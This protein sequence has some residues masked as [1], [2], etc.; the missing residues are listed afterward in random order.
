MARSRARVYSPFRPQ[1]TPEAEGDEDGSVHRSTDNVSL[2][3]SIAESQ[4]GPGGYSTRPTK[5]PSPSL[6]SGSSLANTKSDGRLL[7]A[8][9][10]FSGSRQPSRSMVTTLSHRSATSQDGYSVRAFTRLG[11]REHGWGQIEPAAPFANAKI[12]GR[13]APLNPLSSRGRSPSCQTVALGEGRS[14]RSASPAP[15]KNTVVCLY[16]Q[17]TASGLLLI[18]DQV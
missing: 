8:N 15:S 17:M 2:R 14:V 9:S 1:F 5:S 11:L 12:D 13:L 7:S 10:L 18:K 6:H 3:K 4:L 16:C